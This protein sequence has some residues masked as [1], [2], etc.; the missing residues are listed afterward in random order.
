MALNLA[1]F[2]QVT[3][4]Q[5]NQPFYWSFDISDVPPTIPV[6]Y[7]FVVK[8]RIGCVFHFKKRGSSDTDTSG[9]KLDAA[10]DRARVN[11]SADETNQLPLGLLDVA[12]IVRR[13]NGPAFLTYTVPVMVVR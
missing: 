11:L 8:D 12:L 2:E 9:I 4:L 7:H 13:E 6:S 10:A 3:G 5:R 1:Q